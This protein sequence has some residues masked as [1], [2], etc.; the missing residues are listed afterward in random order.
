MKKYF[1]LLFL[2]LTVS[3]FS[4]ASL[5]QEEEQTQDIQAP[6]WISDRG[7]WQVESNVKTPKVAIIYFYNND[8]VLVYKETIDGIRMNL[9]KKR[10]L[11]C[12]KT[13]LEQTVTAWEQKHAAGEDKDLLAVELRR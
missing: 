2:T 10:I 4:L 3:L 5:A 1:K 6:K 9:K 13:V 12:L 7:Y 11:M 8:R